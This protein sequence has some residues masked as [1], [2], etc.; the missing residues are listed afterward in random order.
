MQSYVFFKGDATGSQYFRIP[1]LLSTSRDTLIAGV[2]VNFGSI[3]DSAENIDLAIRIKPK[4]SAYDSRTGWQEAVLP[5]VMHMHDYADEKGHNPQSASFIDGVI[6]QDEIKTG[7]IFVLAD[8]FAWNGGLFEKLSVEQDGEVKGGTGRKVATGNGFCTIE[9]Q[10]YLLLSS[11]NQ[12]RVKEGQ[13][14]NDNIRRADFDY[15]VN[16]WGQ[17]EP[18]GYYP[19]YHLQGRI[20]QD[21]GDASGV[22][23]GAK[24]QYAINKDYELYQNG[25]P[26]TVIQ[27]SCNQV[28]KLVPMKIFY[29]ESVLQVYNTSYIIQ[30]YSEDE[31]KS[32]HTGQLI[33]GMVKREQAE[34]Y[35]VAPGR[36]LQLK[37]GPNRG[38]L[39]VPV[40]YKG[41][42]TAELIYSD[43]FGKTWQ[44]G[45][46]MGSRLG[47][48][49]LALVEL[50][51]GMVQAFIRN[52]EDYGGKIVTAISK[53][54][55]V[56][57]G[58][59]WSLFGDDEA[60]I[61]CQLSAINYS[62]KVYSLKDGQKYPAVILCSAD[63]RERTDGK[64]WIGLIKPTSKQAANADDMI[65]W[66]YYYRVTPKGQKF[67]YSCL[68]EIQNRE[69]GV[70]YESS[71]DDSWARGLQKI[72]YQQYNLAELISQQK[73]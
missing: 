13:I 28:R 42:P 5:E 61:N 1:F 39:L 12:K 46:S 2:D 55:G 41:D 71:D 44:H 72:Y 27:K 69:I 63:S 53:D 64:I 66:E 38:R 35:I 36:G 17:T 34:Y 16:L 31:G 60:G 57:W 30:F 49:E 24:S 32:W 10:S 51:N 33:S 23:V 18:N 47:L 56:S 65:D 68:A 62:Q 20:D 45:Q 4:A 58:A 59:V 73:N 54:G 37:I 40:Y 19:I 11:K 3:G 52:T 14:I 25:K 70:L 9:G 21:S 26:L 29:E 50:P 7:R 15:I 6:V 8:L 43:D 67:G 22:S 48:S